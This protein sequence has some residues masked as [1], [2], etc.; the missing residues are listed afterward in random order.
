V[1]GISTDLKLSL[2]A[3]F[4]ITKLLGK[5]ETLPLGGLC[6]IPRTRK[7]YY[8]GFPILD[9]LDDFGLI[10]DRQTYQKVNNLVIEAIFD[11]PTSS[12]SPH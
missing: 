11:T 12:N 9:Y 7:I 6:F 10:S 3:S 1:L 5:I 2:S 8:I 4:A